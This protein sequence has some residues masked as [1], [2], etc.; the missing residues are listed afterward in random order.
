MRLTIS[1]LAGLIIAAIAAS[2]AAAPLLTLSSDGLTIV[3][4]ASGGTRELRF[5]TERAPTM[6]AVAAALGAAPEEGTSPE[7]PAGPAETAL[8]DG[9]LTLIFQE[10]RFVGWSLGPQAKADF[11]T[12]SGIRIGSTRREL[13]AAYDASVEET[14]I[15]QEFLA[16][17]LGGTLSSAA[18]DGRID[19]LWAGIV[20][21]LR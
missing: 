2:V 20:C 11:A 5:G 16:G 21:I 15:G 14:S 18:T 7:C 19:N 10:G 3:D 6:T 9:G 13:Q 12:A 4:P 1:S 17:T 8:F